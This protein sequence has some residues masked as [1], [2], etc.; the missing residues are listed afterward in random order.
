MNGNFDKKHRPAEQN[1][2]GGAYIDKN[3]VKSREIWKLYDGSVP[4]DADII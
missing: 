4:N 1:P 3:T 2:L